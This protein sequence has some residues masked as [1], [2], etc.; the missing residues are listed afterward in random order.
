MKFRPIY[1]SA[2]L[3]TAA[4]GAACDVRVGENGVSVDVAGGKASNEWTR[5]YTISPGGA[6]DVVNVNGPI[7]VEAASGPKVEIRAIRTARAGSDEDAQALLKRLEIKEDVTPGRVAIQTVNGNGVGFG[8]R[9]GSVEYRV[10]VPS[11]LQVSVKTENGGIGLH[12][13][14]GTITAATTNGGVRGTNISGAVSAT[15]VNGG[16]VIDMAR[17]AGPI[18]LES[19]NGGIRLEV[20]AD[21]NADVEA[22]AVNGGVSTDDEIGLTASDRSR[23]NL[24][25]KLNR[26][27]VSVSLS[28]VNGGIRI[29]ARDPSAPTQTDKDAF[30][31]A[32]PVLVER[33]KQ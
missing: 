21:V 32:G 30:D 7:V 24:A 31:E 19:V 16:I 22:H 28:T 23:S 26:G 25:G 4:L 2:L 1:L 9:S 18:K 33:R 15:I 8:R 29:G 6:L 17:V 11:G 27:G 12:D 5:T 10:R 13:L 14:D 20:P 3:V